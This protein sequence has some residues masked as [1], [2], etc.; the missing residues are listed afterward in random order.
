M[1]RFEN[2]SVIVSGC[3]SGMGKA[4]SLA[5]MR[6]GA[7][8][9][10]IEYN[11]ESIDAMKSELAAEGLADKFA[12]VCGD[13]R[14]TEKLDETLATALSN[15]GKL[16][17]L[18]DNVG[19]HEFYKTPLNLTDEMWDRVFDIN[20]KSYMQMNRIALPELFK[21]KG[22]IVM[23]SGLCAYHPSAAGLVYIA[24]KN[25][26]EGIMKSTAFYCE[27]KQ[28]GVRVNSV[29]PGAIDTAM[30]VNRDVFLPGEMTS[31]DD[32]EFQF[33]MAEGCISLNR[34]YLPPSEVAKAVLFL[35]SDDA[36]SVTGVSLYVDAGWHGR[37]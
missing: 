25:A 8:V 2:K 31:E 26:I 17:I 22:C 19:V 24:S 18:V 29:L 37:G 15:C 3:G 11:Q 34:Y 6:E 14:N 12:V 36:S 5:F 32:E 21:T 20:V 10:G 30:R 9:T 7:F 16:D 1:S 23:I 35:A 33:Y 13:V 4:I 28:T 27:A